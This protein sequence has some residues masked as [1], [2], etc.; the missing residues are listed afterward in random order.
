MGIFKSCLD[1]DIENRFRRDGT[2]LHRICAVC[3]R[4]KTVAEGS[5]DLWRHLSALDPPQ[6]VV[7]ALERSRPMSITVVYNPFNTRLSEK[8]FMATVNP[9]A[10]IWDE[11]FMVYG[12]LDQAGLQVWESSN[13]PKLH[14]LGVI[15]YSAEY[16]RHPILLNCGQEVPNLQE[17]KFLNVPLHLNPGQLSGLR[18]LELTQCEGPDTAFTVLKLLHLL[19]GT[20]QLRR[21]GL[22][23]MKIEANVAFPGSIT[24]PS[25]TCLELE[26]VDLDAIQQLLSSIHLP[27]CHR[28]Q[29]EAHHQ[30]SDE[31]PTNPVNIPYRE[32][33][34]AI[35]YVQDDRMYLW[36]EGPGTFTFAGFGWAVLGYMEAM[37]EGFAKELASSKHICAVIKMTDRPETP[38]MSSTLTVLDRLPNLRSLELVLSPGTAPLLTLIQ[39][40]GRPSVLPDRV[41]WYLPHLESLLVRAEHAPLL[42]LGQVC[43]ERSR[44]AETS[45]CLKEIQELYILPLNE[46]LEEEFKSKVDYKLELKLDRLQ[47]KLGRGQ[48]FWAWEPWRRRVNGDGLEPT[49]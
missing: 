39:L 22:F 1:T 18:V 13:L 3:H 45:K 27:Q 46:L 17:A 28:D 38:P 2:Q 32:R 5:P 30:V 48:L 37:L 29:D 41:V 26:D 10:A 7:K 49:S 11:A 36:M 14:T 24:C 23:N 12:N 44:A 43:W 16:T 8:A 47:G 33:A 40:L 19:K 9:Y 15:S 20:P 4:W 25:L 6:H 34:F 31:V 21:L 35:L 42:E